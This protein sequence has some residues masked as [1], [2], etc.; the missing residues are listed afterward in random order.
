MDSAEAPPSSLN[1]LSPSSKHLIFSSDSVSQMRSFRSGNLTY[2][3]TYSLRNLLQL[4]SLINISY[5][6]D[7]TKKVVFNYFVKDEMGQH[8]MFALRQGTVRSPLVYVELSSSQ[9]SL[10]LARLWRVELCI[11]NSHSLTHSDRFLLYSV[12]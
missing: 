5:F 7:T 8:L 12:C 4:R 10:F 11:C 2:L 3:L 9:L 1:G 6:L